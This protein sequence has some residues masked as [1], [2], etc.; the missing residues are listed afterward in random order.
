MISRLLCRIGFHAWGYR[1]G[2]L[3]R[4]SRKT[5]RHVNRAWDIE[6]RCIR[7]GAKP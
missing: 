7:C 2:Y 5:L 6:Y 1:G 3:T 4:Q